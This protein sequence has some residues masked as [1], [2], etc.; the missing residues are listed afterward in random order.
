MA[1]VDVEKTL[2]D[3]GAGGV[4]PLDGE[5]VHGDTKLRIIFD[6]NHTN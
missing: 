3:V 6:K 4:G 1:V 5:R 2:V